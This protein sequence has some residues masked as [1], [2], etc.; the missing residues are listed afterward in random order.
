[1]PYKHFTREE[2]E[3]LQ[4]LLGRGIKCK[5]IGFRLGKGPTSVSREV[6][7][8]RKFDGRRHGCSKRSTLCSRFKGCKIEGLCGECTGKRCATCS[9]V[10]CTK[11]CGAFDKMECR[12][13]TRFP[14]V[15]NGCP[16]RSA[17]RLERYSYSAN[18]AQAKADDNASESRRGVDLTGRELADLDALVGPLMRRGQSLNQIYLAHA[19]DIPCSLK[20][21][22]TH[23]N[24]A[25]VGPGRMHLIDAVSR[26]PRKKKPKTDE[27]KPVARKSLAG[28]GW[29]DYLALEDDERDGRW[30]MDTVIGRIG[31]K[32]LLTLLHRPTRFQLALLLERCASAEVAATLEMVA[33]V[34]GR[35][36][37]EVFYLLLTDNGS[38][39]FDAEG[40]EGTLG[41]RLYYCESYS[42]W[43]K[44]AAECNHKYYRRVVPK[45]ASMDSLTARDCAL[46]M[47]HV[48][49]TPRPCLGGTSPVEA[50][51][52]IVGR[53]F[54]DALGVELVGRDEVFLKPEL[55]AG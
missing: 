54:L 11:V 13:T 44:G 48:N 39:F 15:C 41:C 7:R 27:E 12:K 28:R 19:Q 34:M 33:C 53:D 21:L 9:K 40:I 25:E 55:L 52:P 2:R 20:S 1:M 35:P 47:S 49:S 17:C 51:L 29:Q 5:E 8:N 42:S 32:C 14:Y 50:V 37:S 23:V 36:V 43:Q 30:E 6:L 24:K 16:K 22:Y 4:E 10:D 3:E 46:M 31:G 18:V 26:K 38:E 45:G